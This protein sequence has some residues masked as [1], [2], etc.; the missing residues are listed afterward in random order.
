MD[1]L[2]LVQVQGA[3]ELLDVDDVRHFRAGEPQYRER[4]TSVR[5]PAG[6]D[7]HDLDDDVALA[8][9]LDQ[10]AQLLAH[11][12]PAADLAADGALVQ[13]QPHDRRALP[14]ENLLP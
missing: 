6:L 3:G 8:G 7:R 2:A 13:D 9:D 11:D 12:G 10:P 5:V 14:G 4:A 1:V